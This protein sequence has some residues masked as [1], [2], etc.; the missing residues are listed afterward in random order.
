M[1]PAFNLSQDQ[2]LQFN[3]CYCFLFLRIGRS[4]N[5]LT[6]SSHLS[7]KEKTLKTYL[8]TSV[9]LDTFAYTI[10]PKINRS[11][12]TPSAHTY[13]L[14]VFKEHSLK[15]SA[16]FIW[17]FLLFASLHLQQRNEIM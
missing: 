6:S 10:N 2:T 12:R 16:P 7:P 5:V 13:R 11:V 15:T 8:N 9:R 1:P 17:R 3:T 14:L 4:L